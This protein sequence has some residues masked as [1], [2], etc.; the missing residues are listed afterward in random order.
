MKTDRVFVLLLVILLP[1]T[2]CI[3]VSDN[4]GAEDSTESSNDGMTVV[5]HYYN[6]TTT[7]V[8]QQEPDLVHE[9]LSWDE[10]ANWSLTLEGNQA[11]EWVSV[12]AYY[13]I[14]YTDGP[15]FQ[16]YGMNYHVR[17]DSNETVVELGEIGQMGGFAF[18]GEGDCT[19]RMVER[20]DSPNILSLHVHLMYRIHDVVNG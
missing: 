5:N 18:K 16:N 12:Y 2:G 9:Y 4:A 14:D 3:D 15:E 1:M 8:Q 19:Y 6:N 10:V 11:V 17:C 20:I 7:I 13:L